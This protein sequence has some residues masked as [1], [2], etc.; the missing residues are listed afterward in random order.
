MPTPQAHAASEYVRE[1]REMAA[2][3][4]RLKAELEEW[5]ATAGKLREAI[6]RFKF[7]RDNG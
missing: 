3:I 6:S 5:K 1:H 4:V 2:E 7:E